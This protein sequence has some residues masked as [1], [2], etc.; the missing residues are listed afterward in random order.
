LGKAEVHQLLEALPNLTSLDL[1]H[2]GIP[3]EHLATCPSLPPLQELK[4]SIS[5]DPNSCIALSA[6]AVLPCTF[7]YVGPLGDDEMQ[8]FKTW[9][10]GQE[11]KNCLG[12]L[13]GMHWYMRGD[14]ESSRAQPM[15]HAAL[16][17]LAEAAGQLRHL[18]LTGPNNASVKD[19]TLLRGLKQLTSLSFKYA[20]PAD[21]DVVTPLAALPNLR[22]L[23]VSGG[24][25]K[26]QADPVRAAVAAGQL[27]SLK[28]LKMVASL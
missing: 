7:L 21:A 16:A 22:H 27:P 28:E 24:L 4:L 25:S 6:L 12:R 19:V 15:S 2:S 14:F 17:C 20:G 11:G 3:L 18:E 13:T 5:L 23:T 8:K 9:S 1:R 26:G 10:S